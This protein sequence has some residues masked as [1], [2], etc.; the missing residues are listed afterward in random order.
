[1]E[2][3]G[4]GLIEPP[5]ARCACSLGSLDLFGLGNVGRHRFSQQHMNAGLDRR[6]C[7]LCCTT[8]VMRERHVL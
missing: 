3:C 7:L 1:L 8:K 4:K 5:L 2:G 6:T